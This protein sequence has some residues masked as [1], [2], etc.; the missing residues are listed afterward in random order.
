MILPIQCHKN[1]FFVLYFIA[2]S[3]HGFFRTFTTRR[4]FASGLIEIKKVSSDIWSDLKC[5]L[6]LIALASDGDRV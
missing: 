5:V 1:D 4:R 2:K 6:L 3:V